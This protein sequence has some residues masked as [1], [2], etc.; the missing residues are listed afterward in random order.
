[1]TRPITTLTTRRYNW[2]LLLHTVG[3]IAELLPLY[4][5]I[6]KIL[7]A[8]VTDLYQKHQNPTTEKGN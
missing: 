2:R 3:Q 5:T 4:G 8:A 1:M 7:D 6:A